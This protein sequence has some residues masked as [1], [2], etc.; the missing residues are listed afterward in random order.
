MSN[1]FTVSV[2]GRPRGPAPLT[3][4]T[5]AFPGARGS[6][7]DR[8]PPQQDPQADALHPDAI[9]RLGIDTDSDATSTTSRSASC[10]RRRS[11][12]PDLRRHVATGAQARAPRAVGSRSSSSG[13]VSFGPERRSWVGRLDV[14]RRSPQR[15]VL[16]LRRRIRTSSCQGSGT[17]PPTRFGGE[18]PW[19]GDRLSNAEASV[20]S[21]AVRD[22]TRRSVL[23]GCCVGTLRWRHRS[24]RPGRNTVSEQLLQH[25]RGKEVQR[26]SPSMERWTDLFV[27]L[28]GHRRLHGGRPSPSRRRLL[29]DITDLRPVPAGPSA[30]TAGVFLATSSTTGCS[31]CPD[32]PPPRLAHARG[33]PRGFSAMAPGRLG[34]AVPSDP[35]ATRRVEFAIR[36]GGHGRERPYARP[37]PPARP[38]RGESR[39]GGKRPWPTSSGSRAPGRGRAFTTPASTRGDAGH[40]VT[41]AEVGRVR[42]RLVATRTPRRDG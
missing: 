25:R 14:L 31:S 40:A 3:C 13:P 24:R 18:A 17:S 1:H 30:R 39:A 16:R 2:S 28:M 38:P 9:Y 20:F 23:P 22:A 5:S 35:A 12:Q 27:H 6:H 7:A 42:G 34:A 41:D 26:A 11:R 33:H 15:R 32:V 29:P 10:S 36:G 21:M 19:I 4:A 8:P 37:P